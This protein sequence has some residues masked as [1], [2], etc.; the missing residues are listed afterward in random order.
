MDLVL[1]K[2]L[3]P[4][5]AFVLLAT[6]DVFAKK[7]EIFVHNDLSLVYKLCLAEPSQRSHGLAQLT[8]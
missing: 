1:V 3:M 7:V 5:N 2:L 4:I 8:T 6:L